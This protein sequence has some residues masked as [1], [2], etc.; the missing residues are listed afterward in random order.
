MP[1]PG[2]HS[3]LSRPL[4]DGY[5]IGMALSAIAPVTSGVPG[6]AIVPFAA[7]PLTVAIV[8]SPAPAP[9][10][11]PTPVTNPADFVLRGE[12]GNQIQAW[13]AVALLVA[14]PAVVANLTRAIRPAVPPVAPVTGPP[15]I[16][17]IDV[18][19]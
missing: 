19:A 16:H 18:Y 1:S 12:S 9:L 13:G 5:K 2:G 8:P 11:R 14:R 10:A 6:T 17:L 4:V 7:A 15:G 3:A